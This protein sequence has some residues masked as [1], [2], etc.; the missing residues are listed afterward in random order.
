M[1]EIMDYINAKK[2][3]INPDYVL[4]NGHKLIWQAGKFAIMAIKSDLTM[5]RILISVGRLTKKGFVSLDYIQAQGLGFGSPELNVKSEDGVSFHVAR[6]SEIAKHTF[7][8]P[9]SPIR[10]SGLR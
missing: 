3:S 5:D 10:F 1:E 7:I 4:D 8:K 2:L 9:V 6:L